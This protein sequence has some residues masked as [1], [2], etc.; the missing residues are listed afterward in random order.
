MKNLFKSKI[1]I[2]I[3][4][5]INIGTVKVQ[6]ENLW[7]TYF[8]TNPSQVKWKEISTHKE[9]TEVLNINETSLNIIP[10]SELLEIYLQYPLLLDIWAFNNL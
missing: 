8:P 10:T 3:L 9:M 7:Q 6:K 5:F 4:L 2:I 1:I